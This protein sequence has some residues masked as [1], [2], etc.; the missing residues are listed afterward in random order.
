MRQII[1][2]ALK[3]KYEGVMKE[4]AANIEIYLRNPNGIGEHPEILD[5][6]DTQLA[7][8]MDAHEKRGA[9]KEFTNV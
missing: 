4:A 5:A 3:A 2:D 1:L 9:L 6:I 7:K 8:L